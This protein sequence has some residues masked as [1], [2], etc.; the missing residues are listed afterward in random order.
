VSATGEGNRGRDLAHLSIALLGAFQVRLDGKPADRFDTLKTRALLAYLA[1]EPGKVHSRLALADILWPERTEAQALNNLRNNLANLRS[2]IEDGK[3]RPA[4]LCVERDSIAFNPES[5][6]TIDSVEFTRLIEDFDARGPSS[7]SSLAGIEQAVSLYKGDF[8]ETMPPLK[9]AGLEEWVLSRRSKYRALQI[10]GLDRLTEA[11]LARADFNRAAGLAR[12]QL[13]IEPWREEA[14]QQLMSALALAGRRSEAL[15]EFGI[16]RDLFEKELGVGLGQVTLQLF[17]SIRTGRFTP[18]IAFQVR[19]PGLELSQAGRQPFPAL[20]TIPAGKMNNLPRSL[21]SLIGR[22]EEMSQ[23]KHLFA[24]HRLLTLTGDG[25]VGKSRMAVAAAA[26]LADAFG[27]G[28]CMIELAHLEHPEQVPDAVLH[29]LGL[30]NGPH[31]ASPTGLSIILGSR[32]ILLILDNCEHLIAPVADLVRLLLRTCPDLKILATSREKLGVEGE[33]C[34]R[35]PMLEF[36]S[37][38]RL[39]ALKTSLE[40]TAVKL[41]VERAQAVLP[42]F[43]VTEGN[44]PAIA[45]ICQRLDGV[46]LALELA[47]AHLEILTP[48]QLAARLDGSFHFLTRGGLNSPPRHQTL[49]AVIDWSYEMLSTAERLFLARLSVFTGGWTLE[50]AETVCAGETIAGVDVL[51]LLMR[52]VN[53]SMVSGRRQADGET[54]FYLLE[55]VRQFAQE[56]LRQIEEEDLLRRRHC[57]YFLRLSEIAW[58]GLHNGEHLT[59]MKKLESERDNIFRAISWAIDE[60]GDIP[61]G[62]RLL[63]ILDRWWH[64]RGY[65]DQVM[66]WLSKGISHWDDPPQEIKPLYVGAL[67][68]LALGQTDRDSAFNMIG[69][70][71][72]LAGEFRPE[73]E[74]ISMVGA[75]FIASVIFRTQDLDGNAALHYLNLACEAYP[76][77]QDECPFSLW[78]LG[79]ILDEKSIAYYYLGD[80]TLAIQLA[81]ESLEII[82]KTGDHWYC[83]PLRT[84]GKIAQRQGDYASAREYF[85]RALSEGAGVEDAWAIWGLECLADLERQ[86]GHYPEAMARLREAIRL[87]REQFPYFLAIDL[88]EGLAFIKILCSRGGSGLEQQQALVQAAVFLGAAQASRKIEELKIFNSPEPACP[89]LIAELYERLEGSQLRKAWDEGG[90]LNIAQATQYA[91]N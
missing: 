87:S 35:V 54:R 1:D 31:Q 64:L 7:S 24:A 68:L 16:F 50:S 10:E 28:V 51:D 70:A 91:L 44:W 67:S 72:A 84:L 11:C 57:G 39:P 76:D 90:S 9:S 53:K 74:H 66:R 47:A 30:G 13:A 80:D 25:G 41:L 5:E 17:E 59:W 4:Y 3:A 32:Q 23:V 88:L 69:R 89:E 18:Q 19:E 8:L 46:P 86:F 71:L 29:A 27:D 22:E 2:A 6:S 37:P 52:L 40:F 49:R 12:Q 78:V 42:S 21:T 26:E 14:F 15:V 81:L 65:D 60:E 38:Q 58:P 61:C 56:K 55:T 83:N 33:A 34:Y 79:V 77:F 62:L 82:Q 20:T 45:F 75:L 36:P 63:F 73:D 43:T 85:E 48:M